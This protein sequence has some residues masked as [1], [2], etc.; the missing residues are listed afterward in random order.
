MEKPYETRNGLRVYSRAHGQG[1]F[2]DQRVQQ[3]GVFH[4]QALQR[5]HEVNY[6]TGGE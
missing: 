4:P 6:V 2:I 1:A 5:V 3:W